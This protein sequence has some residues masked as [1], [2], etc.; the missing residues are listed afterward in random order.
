MSICLSLWQKQFKSTAPGSTATLFSVPL[1]CFSPEATLIIIADYSL[2]V[3]RQ[4]SFFLKIGP[5]FFCRTFYFVFS[6]FLNFF[7]FV[8]VAII[9]S[10]VNSKVKFVLLSQNT[11]HPIANITPVVIKDITF[12]I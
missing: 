7:I 6:L 9:Q 12:A 4:F 3:K 10:A 2:S 11:K 8:P 1:I 5:N